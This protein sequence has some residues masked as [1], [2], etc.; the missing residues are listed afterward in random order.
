M[1]LIILILAVASSCLAQLDQ[2]KD[3]LL[4]PAYSAASYGKVTQ[5]VKA[6]ARVVTIVNPW[7]GPGTKSQVGE[8]APKL[9]L[10]RSCGGILV[11]YIDLYQQPGDGP[12]GNVSEKRLKTVDELKAEIDL[13]KSYGVF[14]GYF[15]DDAIENTLVLVK[16][17]LPLLKGI[18]ILNPGKPVSNNYLLPGVTHVITYENPGL[19]T[20]PLKRWE[21]D[22]PRKTGYMAL[23]IKAPELQT[24]L[25]VIRKGKPGL[26]WIDT[27]KNFQV[28]PPYFDILASS[29][30]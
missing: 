25:M 8:Y 15:L 20:D 10:L 11:A 3:Y 24:S 28:L 9:G 19:R 23:F 14:A 26:I 29:F 30:K 4:V 16:A 13:Y 2:S 1:K 6:K 22:N 7:S 27:A 5:A 17:I 18:V 12:K 21:R